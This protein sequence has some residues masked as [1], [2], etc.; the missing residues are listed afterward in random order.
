[1]TD[2]RNGEMATDVM[3]SFEEKFLDMAAAGRADDVR[4]YL[5]GKFI[6]IMSLTVFCNYSTLMVTKG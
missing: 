2:S 5:K 3:K 4:I 1:M 6:F